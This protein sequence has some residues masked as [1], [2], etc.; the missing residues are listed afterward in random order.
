MILENSVVS[1][2]TS[3]LAC[4]SHCIIITNAET[5]WVELSC[6]KFMPRLLP[7]LAQIRVI[8]ARSNYEWM[9]PDS[10]LE[11]KL[12]AFDAELS[13]LFPLAMMPQAAPGAM[14]NSRMTFKNIISFGDSFHEREAIYKVSKTLGPQVHTKS[15]KFVERPTIEQLHYQVDMVTGYF[16]HILHHEDDL[17][18][19]LSIEEPLRASAMLR[20]LMPVPPPSSSN[21]VSSAALGNTQSAGR[22]DILR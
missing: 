15:I 1:L 22:P 4:K 6:A 16:Q 19:M 7:Y 11:W 3:I 13:T 9:Y 18:L 10:P 14:E 12:A 21:V 2:F 5:G 20:P 8:S 17:D